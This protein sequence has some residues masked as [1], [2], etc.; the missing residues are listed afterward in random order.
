MS[1]ARH[2]QIIES[3]YPPDSVYTD[4]ESIGLGIMMTAIMD[5]MI[6]QDLPDNVLA[7]MAAECELIDARAMA[8]KLLGDT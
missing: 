2:I 4:T 8:K 6:W 5:G 7:M 3:L 1:R